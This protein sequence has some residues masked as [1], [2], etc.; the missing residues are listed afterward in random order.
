MSETSILIS[1]ALDP[2]RTITLRNAFSKAMRSRFRSFTGTLV[3]VIVDD[4]V[5]GVKVNRKPGQGAFAF[6]NSAEK[7][8]AFM[9]WFEELI[10]NEILQITQ[11]EQVTTSV[12]SMWMNPFIQDAYKKGIMKARTQLI[13]P[14]VN[15]NSKLSV[16][17][18]PPRA[19]KVPPLSQTGGVDASLTIPAHM[20]RLSM[21]YSRTFSELKGV[22]AAMSQMVSRILAEGLIN[23]T[24]PTTLAKQIVQAVSGLGEDLSLI[25]SLGRFIPAEVRAEMIARTEIIRAHAEAQLTE[26]EN[27]GVYGVVAK[28]EIQTTKDQRT[29]PKCSRLEKAVMTIEEARGVIPVHPLCR[30]IWIPFIE[31]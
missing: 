1:Q 6:P 30:C 25:D 13:H 16:N 28:A 12:N 5:F 3:E 9:R 18:K 24:S 4:N 10:I 23:G 15:V 7:I 11:V 17:A 20:E 21:L 19:K 27:W 14:V 29:C 31:Q 22:T 2:S 26:F 8:T